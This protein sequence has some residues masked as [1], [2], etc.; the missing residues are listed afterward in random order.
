MVNTLKSLSLTGCPVF[1]PFQTAVFAHLMGLAVL[2]VHLT[3]SIHNVNSFTEES[4][5]KIQIG[6]D[7]FFFL[8]ADKPG[9]STG[10]L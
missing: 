9:I 4:F 1:Y 2:V 5:S 7:L 3:S 6:L 10:A 8:S